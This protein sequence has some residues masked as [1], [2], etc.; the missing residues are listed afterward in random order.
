M[1]KPCSFSLVLVSWSLAALC[2]GCGGSSGGGAPLPAAP[3]GGNGASGSGASSAPAPSPAPSPAAAP[4]PSPAPSPSVA[5][6]PAPAVDDLATLS[7]EF[8]DAGAVQRFQRVFQVEQWGF[9]QLQSF[10]ANGTRPGWATLVPHTSSWY[11]DYRGVLAF[12]A[13]QGDFVATAH[14]QASDRAGTG[15][16][17][18]RRYSLAGIMVRAPRA[19]TPATWTPGGEN[20]VFLS[21]G[22]ASVPGVFQN[23]V[24]TTLQGDSQLEVTPAPSGGEATLRVARLGGAVITLLRPVGGAWQVH[25]R[26]ARGDLPQTLQVGLT[27]YTDWD[28]IEA[29]YTAQQHNTTLIL[30][31]QPDLRAQFDYLRYARP[32]VPAAL[33]GR[34]PSD[35]G[36]VSDAELLAFLGN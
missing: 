19:I 24:K 8:D 20:Y 30:G 36:Q 18:A 9:D 12:K 27:T 31:G 26:Y 14:V 33:A 23:E 28:T 13:V 15:A 29:G 5:P 3:A 4:A 22:A 16:A 10:D 2:G 17:P 7:E 1:R 6:A 21:L 25:R 32:V 35:P 34:D 11:R